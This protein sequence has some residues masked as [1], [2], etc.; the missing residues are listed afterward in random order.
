[1]INDM[2]RDVF[3]GKI[4]FLIIAMLIF[5][6][7]ACNKNIDSAANK[8]YLSV[9]HISPDAPPLDIFFEGNKLNTSGQLFFDSTTGVPGDPYLTAIAGIHN[10][11]LSSGSQ[12]FVD[13]SIALQRTHHYS[14]FA[15]DSLV[16]GDSLRRLILEDQ[17]SAPVDTI[18]LVRFLN[19]C[20]TS[21]YLGL[22]NATDTVALTYLRKIQ[23][24]TDPT[25]LLYS[26]IKSGAY[27]IIT[28]KDSVLPFFLDSLSV[29]GGKIYTVFITGNTE[30][31][32]PKALRRGLIQH[33]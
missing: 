12:S 22:V 26:R 24:N 28:A 10:L 19:F 29:T 23:S 3:H 6:I 18:S 9:T 2:K 17:L 31:T 27:Q 16:N 4:F 25:T 11:K 21:F 8:A 1:M 13:G 14:L 32:N 7:I 15:Y 5:F 33:N 30:S 20:D